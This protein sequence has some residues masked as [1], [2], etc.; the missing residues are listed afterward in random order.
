V[1][2]HHAHFNQAVQEEKKVWVK[3]Y[4]TVDAR[5]I[6]RKFTPLAYGQGSGFEDGL[7]RYWLWDYSGATGLHAVGM[8]PQ[9]IVELSVL[10]DLFDPAEL[11]EGAL[12]G[13]GRGP[14]A[15]DLGGV[16]P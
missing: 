10:G 15:V 9:Q 11:M 4:S 13:A 6:V 8:L 12:P 5:V 7:N 3:F 1:N 16:E 2:F 14:S